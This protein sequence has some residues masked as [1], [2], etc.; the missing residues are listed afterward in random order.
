M[1]ATMTSYSTYEQ[2]RHAPR[3]P[4]QVES[5]LAKAVVAIVNPYARGRGLS[6]I[7]HVS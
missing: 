4:E 2:L 7:C 3:T 1:L 5:V 6:N